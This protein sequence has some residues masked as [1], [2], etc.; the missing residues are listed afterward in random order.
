MA[1]GIRVSGTRRS[2]RN[3]R[4]EESVGNRGNTEGMERAAV[5]PAGARR[6]ARRENGREGEG[7]LG[8]EGVLIAQ[9]RPGAK[10]GVLVCGVAI[11]LGDSGRR[12]GLW[13]YM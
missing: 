9:K 7:A 10:T 11:G 5:I 2:E 4:Q 1:R 12:Q 13:K 6:P 3:V 8:D